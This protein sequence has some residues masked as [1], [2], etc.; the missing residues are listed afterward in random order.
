MRL[1]ELY[2]NYAE[3]ANEAYGPN[4]SAPGATLTAVQ[5]LNVIRTRAGQPN[6]KAAFTVSTA[7]LRPRIRNERSVEFAFE[8]H[9][10]HD[11]RRW[12]DAPAAYSSTLYAMDIEKVTTSATYPI[13]YRHTRRALPAD[14]QPKWIEPMY[15]L[16]FN[17]EDNF[18]MKKFV[19][20]IVW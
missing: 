14:R 18:K 4:G 15:Y 5:A 19:P 11:I 17:T 20:N 8:G 12:M 9:Y 10:Y 13:G 6:V 2:L 3:A 1:A 16:P 7:T